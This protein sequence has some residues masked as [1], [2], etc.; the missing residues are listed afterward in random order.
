M[1]VPDDFRD[2][3]LRALVL[4]GVVLFVFTES[5]GALDLLRR[6][7]LL[8]CWGIVVVGAVTF[9]AKRR[10]TFR[11]AS[12]SGFGD[13]VTLICTIGIAAILTLT[14]LTAAYS[15]PNSA[16]AMAYHMPRIVYWTEQSSVRFFPTPYFNQIMLQ[17]LAEYAMLHTYLLSGGDHFINFVQWFASLASIIGVS[18][19]A[20]MFGARPRGQAIAAL[21][22]VTLPSGILASTGAKN[23]YFLAMWLVTAVYF[24][25]RFTT[26]DQPTD[27]IFFGTALGLAMLTKATA[28]LFAPWILVAILVGGASRFPRRLATGAL[29]AITIGLAINL[30]LYERNYGL[31]GSILGFDSAQGDGFF[32]WRNESFGW[33]QTLS[34]ILRNSS[35]QLGARSD[36]W[37]QSVFEFVVDVHRW[38]RIDIND[39]RTTWRSSSFGPP[40]NANHEANAPNRWHLTILVVVSCILAWRAFRGRDR[41]RAFYALALAAAFVAFSAYLKWQPFQARLLLPLFVLGAPLASVIGETARVVKA[42]IGPLC[43]QIAVCLFLL[44]NARPAVME[45]W[46]RPLKGQRSVLHTPREAQYFADMSQWNNQASYWKTED[47][48]TKSSCD[49]IGIDITNLQLEYPL[50]ALV[51][52]KRPGARFLH[53]GVQNVSE[54]YAQPVDAAPC[55]VACLDCAGDFKRLSLYSNF[56]KCALVDKFVIFLAK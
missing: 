33:R 1:P 2:R 55:A 50:Q 7:T 40:K 21:F 15:P 20:R 53:T 22:C 51:R 49:V 47:L 13:P 24:A 35:E 26:T 3:F 45:N 37:N 23:D 18:G 54:R 29:I 19:V 36:K 25:L 12:L 46:V 16:D 9:A 31:S 27:A 4:L 30:P 44:N 6:G 17:P 52:A 11:F 34:N 56:P 28:Y 8:V 14:A 48:L 41:E 39:P 32:R 42:P 43:V 10:H 38:L 5:L